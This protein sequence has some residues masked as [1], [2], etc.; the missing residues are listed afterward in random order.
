ML[1][2]YCRIS[3]KKEEG[4]DTSIATQ[5]RQGAEFAAKN[6]LTFKYYVD[7]GISGQKGVDDRDALDEMFKDIEAKKIT[8]VWV[9]DQSRFER[10]ETL[11]FDFQTLV[12]KYKIAFYTGN[13][14][15]DLED[16][17]MRVMTNIMSVMNASFARRTSKK[18]KDSFIQRITQKKAIG[19]TAY[20]YKKG[21]DGK[22]VID[23]EESIIVKRIFKLSLE[24]NGA[25]TIANILNR[26]NIPTRYNKYNG[27]I[28]KVDKYT[29]EETTFDKSSI[30]WRGNVIS[31]IIQNKIYKGVRVFNHGKEN[32]ITIDSPIIIEPEFYDKVIENLSSNKKK[33]GKREE[34]KYLLNG[35]ITCENCGKKMRGKKREKGK[36]SAYKCGG[37]MN[38]RGMNIE[39]LE[40]F[41]IKHLFQSKTLKELLNSSRPVSESRI[42]GVKLK[43]ANSQEELQKINKRIERMLLVADEVED[44]ETFVFQFKKAK[45]KKTILNSKVKKLK[46]EISEMESNFSL[47]HFNNIVEGFEINQG[48]DTVKASIHSLIESIKVG[49]F[50]QEK[51][52]YF[53]LMLEYKHFGDISLFTT[54]HQLMKWFWAQHHRE[55][56]TNKE[57]EYQDKELYE[58]LNKEEV[59]ADFSGYESVSIMAGH[60]VNLSKDELVKFN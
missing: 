59:P 2:I 6:G 42:D 13:I 28:T 24:G 33:V 12:V 27:Q 39:K 31:G 44:D 58:Y 4:V 55:G 34:Y 7:K 22:L 16:E 19:L 9:I 15:F 43:L 10:S 45:E 50:K 17:D 29:K 41:V 51:G 46:E 36:D 23:E 35:L 38:C 8:S 14:R 26:E 21:E 18:V 1:A 37:G 47:T 49:H 60:Q 25:Y 32:Q 3:K 57:E 20:G 11:W 54:N 48:F 40:T 52:G 56:F 5:Q 53:I 30:K